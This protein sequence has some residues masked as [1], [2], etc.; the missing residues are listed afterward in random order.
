MSE[1][2]AMKGTKSGIVI[3]LNEEAAFEE[4][5][6]AVS[7]KFK[8]SAAFWGEAT[9]AVSFQGKKLSDDEKMQ[10]VD[11]I[12]E[13]C[14]LLIPCIMEE[15]EALET[16]FQNSI[17]N[18]QEEIDYSTGQFFK[19]NLRSGQVLV[20]KGNVI[21]LGSLKGNVYAG[22]SGNTNAFVVA[23]DMDPV[24]IRIADTI[25]RSPDKPRKKKEK[26]TKIAFW[27]DGNIYIEPLD[28]DV[29]GDIRL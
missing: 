1:L 16:A 10:L 13:N 12:Q 27:E 22:S 19:G 7:E 11:C 3:V 25:A 28:K 14:H 20:S 15:D 23:L 9:K 26:E 17:E 21:I 29:M 6:Q 24:Q 5:K 8:E 18:R 4:L 2:V